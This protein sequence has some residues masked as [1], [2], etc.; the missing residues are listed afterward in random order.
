MPA[1]DSMALFL[2]LLTPPLVLAEQAG[3]EK[4]HYVRPTPGNKGYQGECTFTIEKAKAGWTIRSVT[5][6]AG[7]GMTVQ[8]RYDSDDRLLEASATFAKGDDKSTATVTVSGGR[9]KVQRAGKPAEEFPVPPGLIVTSAP[10]WTDTFLLCR[11]YD[12]KKGG[13]QSFTG[14]WIHPAQPALLLP[15]T[16]E[17]EGKDQVEAGG[18]RA[19]FDRYIIKIRGPNPYLAWADDKGTMV[20]LLPLPY[21]EGSLNWLALQGQE[22]VAAR[23]QPPAQK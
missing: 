20:K 13:K 23:L 3:A 14:L 22:L 4:L 12:R 16:I 1:H 18:K 8:A 7:A 10:D 5:G 15:F 21:R 19:E 11:R 9:A 2:I 6:R 17:R